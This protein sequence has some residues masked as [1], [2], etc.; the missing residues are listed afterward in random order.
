VRGRYLWNKRD[1]ESLHRAIDDF[2]S[3]IDADPLDAKAY[4]GMADC[5]AQLGYG[6]YLPPGE[7]FPKAK[8]AA[9]RAI[10][11]EPS[12]AEAH[13]SLGY[14]TMYCDWDFPAAKRHYEE[15]IRLNP[16]Y[17]PAHEWYAYLL[18]ATKRP[19][20][21]AIARAREARD[22]DPLA[23]SSF[24]DLAL[25]QLYYGDLQGSLGSVR[26]ALELNPSFPPAYFWLARIYTNQKRFE[27]AE[28]A[29]A[30][31]EKLHG[32][33]P[34]MAARGVLYGAWGKPEKARAVLAEF[35]EMRRH[36][37]YVAPYATAGIHVW[38][39]EKERALD[40]LEDAFRERSHWLIWLRSDPRWAP[41]RDEPRFVELTRRVGLPG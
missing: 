3:A 36:G 14:T 18:T 33:T 7:A 41:L 28:A 39:G 13:A 9:S 30:K 1:E 40:L 25:V 8:A 38:L 23:P 10:E 21:E 4:A 17:A 2:R 11:L 34:L 24:T 37:K 12:L 5:Y 19:M 26:A 6:S 29:A 27:E 31:A 15:A 20:S 35:E 22:L 16:S 32:F